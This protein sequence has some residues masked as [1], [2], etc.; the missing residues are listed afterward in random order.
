MTID[1]VQDSLTA[2]RYALDELPDE[3]KVLHVQICDTLGLGIQVES[4]SGY[5]TD[6]EHSRKVCGVK[7][8]ES[9]GV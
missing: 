5:F 3:A 1:E 4:G 7:V 2:I 8:Y 6:G 9:E